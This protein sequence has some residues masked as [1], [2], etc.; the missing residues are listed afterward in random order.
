M[1][2]I[3]LSIVLA[4]LALGLFTGTAAAQGNQPSREGRGVM[5]DYLEQALADKLGL[6]VAEVEAQFDAGNTL[7]QIA[8]DN[9]IAEADLTTFMQEVHEAAFAAAVSDGVLTQAQADL[10]LQRMASRGYGTGACPMGG[11]RPQD[12]SGYGRGHGMGMHGGRWSQ[13][14]P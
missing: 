5:H 14:N 4:L 3:T 9:G 1:K 12:G 6:T 10:M 2:K 7:W 8:L 11:A 13:T